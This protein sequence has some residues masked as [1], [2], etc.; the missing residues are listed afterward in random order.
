MNIDFL[1][2]NTQVIAKV[3]AF[4]EVH[5][6]R[7][8]SGIYGYI[9]HVSASRTRLLLTKCCVHNACKYSFPQ[10]QHPGVRYCHGV[11]LEMHIHR[12]SSGIY[13]YIRHVSVS[14]TR[15]LL[16]KCCVHNACKYSFPQTQHPGVRYC[17]GVCLEMHI[18]SHSSG[19]YGWSSF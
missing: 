19:I 16:T 10:T 6:H 14:R 2:H 3:M 7:Y 8:S 13:G 12:Y 5:I 9:R 1:K 4:F 17:H 15:L 11:C 18:H